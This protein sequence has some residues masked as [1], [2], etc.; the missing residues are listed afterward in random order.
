MFVDLNHG[1]WDPEPPDIDQAE[2]AM[3]AIAAG[4]VE[5]A[6]TAAWLRERVRFADQS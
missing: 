2:E 1:S 3:L 4:E 5:E 6:W